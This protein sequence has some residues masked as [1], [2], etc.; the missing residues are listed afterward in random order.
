MTKLKKINGSLCDCLPLLAGV[1][2][3]AVLSMCFT[4]VEWGYSQSNVCGVVFSFS[5]CFSLVSL[6]IWCSSQQ[7]LQPWRVSGGKSKPQQSDTRFKKRYV[8]EAVVFIFNLVSHPFMSTFCRS[9]DTIPEG[10]IY[11]FWAKSPFICATCFKNHVLQCSR[12]LNSLLF[13]G[14]KILVCITTRL[15]RFLAGSRTK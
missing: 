15:E 8:A 12:H 3:D 13:P 6:I 2:A 11:C 4:H 5:L 14:D 1:V 7:P 10:I 9:K